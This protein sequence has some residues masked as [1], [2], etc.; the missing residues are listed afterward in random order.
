MF[1]R[2]KGNQRVRNATKCEYDEIKFKSKLEMFCYKELKLS[3]LEFT[4]EENT[5]TLIPTFSPTIPVYELNK[6]VNLLQPDLG[7]VRACTYTPDFV[8]RNQ[9]KVFVLEI[10][11]MEQDA[12]KLKWKMFRQYIQNFST[13]DAL[14]LVKNQKQVKECI[15]IIKLNKSL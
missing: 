2:I 10:K 4:Y 11:G 7:K 6:K 9:G 5:Y 14:F 13:C 1:K 8:V 15:E 3:K 12:W